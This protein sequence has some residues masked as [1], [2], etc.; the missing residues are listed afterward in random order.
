MEAG[1]DPLYFWS[2]TAGEI[3]AIIKGYHERARW[4]A[5]QTYTTG[6]LFGKC[7]SAAFGNGSFPS[8][9]K[10]FPALFD[11]LPL[12]Q[13]QPWEIMKEQVL[14][15]NEDYKRNRGDKT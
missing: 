5:L 15:H 10:V 6:V 2:L 12:R 3:L 4:Q 9:Q 13:K 7:L 1:I 8:I 11:D 14:A